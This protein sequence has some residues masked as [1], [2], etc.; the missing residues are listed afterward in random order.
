VPA[1]GTGSATLQI[2]TSQASSA[3]RPLPMGRWSL[4]PLL[5][6][7]FV[8]FAWRARRRVLLPLLALAMALVSGLTACS[9]SGGGGG[10][11]PP[12]NPITHTTPAGTY[13]IPVTISSTGVQ[14]TVTLTLIVD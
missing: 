3:A 7:V 13:S 14:H 10:S 11:T 9:S 1:N 12:P 5:A 6:L 2:T 4:A 8:P